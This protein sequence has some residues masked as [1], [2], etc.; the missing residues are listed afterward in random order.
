MKFTD[1][2]PEELI[3][4]LVLHRSGTCYGGVYG[5]IKKITAVTK[6]SFKLEGD[7]NLFNLQN[8]DQRGL[9]GKM[10]MGVISDCKLITDEEAIELKKKWADNRDRKRIIKLVQ[11]KIIVLNLA[12]LQEIEKLIV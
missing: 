2:K 11:D 5:S 12:T 6:T 7:N 4:K 9:N 1:F 8:G 3:G 10:Y